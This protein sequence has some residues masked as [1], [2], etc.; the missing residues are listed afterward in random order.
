[1]SNSADLAGSDKEAAQDLF[2]DLVQTLPNFDDLV[3]DILDEIRQRFDGVAAELR[4]LASGWPLAWEY[5]SDDRDAF[6]RA[7]RRFSSNYAPAFGTLLNSAGRWHQDQSACSRRHSR[8]AIR[9]L[10]FLTARG[11]AMSAIRPLVLRPVSPDGS[12]TST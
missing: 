3:N 7:V 6:V 10:C 8:S 5:S 2:E 4:T 1:M 11:W 12:V 9:A